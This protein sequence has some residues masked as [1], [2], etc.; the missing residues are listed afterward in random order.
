MRLGGEG[1]RAR[2]MFED[3]IFGKLYHGK[4]LE[5]VPSADLEKLDDD[6]LDWAQRQHAMLD[7]REGFEDLQKQCAGHAGRAAE[8]AQQI[9]DEMQAAQD[10]ASAMQQALASAPSSG[11]TQ[12]ALDGL[13]GVQ[14]YGGKWSGKWEPNQQHDPKTHKLADKLR[15]DE[16]LKKIAILAGKFRRI[17]QNKKRQ[18]TRSDSD[19][20]TDIEQGREIQ[21]L[22]PTELVRLAHPKLKWLARRDLLEGR[23]LQY[24]METKEELGRGPMI[25]CVDK[26]PSMEGDPDVW[27]CA[28]GLALM[29][30]V[31]RE[32]RDFIL[33]GFNDDVPQRIVVRRGRPMPEEALAFPLSGGTDIT[34]V[35][36]LALNAVDTRDIMSRAD[37]VLVTDGVSSTQKASWIKQRAAKRDVR[38]FG[39]GIGVPKRS[40]RPWCDIVHAITDLNAID[41]KTTEVLAGG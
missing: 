33:L 17:L 19:A 9:V 32:G 34:N 11:Q 21:R 28:V 1:D 35:L 39:I 31:H 18:L 23:A 38:I 24:K 29:D 26:S 3:E 2:V 41:D 20:V 12:D 5:L 15:K 37:I 8:A 6:I 25:L 7:N 10:A 13:A 27:A 36:D 16:R 40:L 22:L 14:G 4:D 30:V